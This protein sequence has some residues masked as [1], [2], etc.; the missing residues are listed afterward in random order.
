VP[1]DLATGDKVR[2]RFENQDDPSFFDPSIADV[3]SMPA[4]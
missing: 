1:A 4:S 2:V 3:W